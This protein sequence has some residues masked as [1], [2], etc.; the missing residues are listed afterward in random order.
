MFC[1]CLKEN[2]T[3][4]REFSDGDDLDID[5]RLKDDSITY[6]GQ[7]AYLHFYRDRNNK[8][9]IRFT[10]NVVILVEITNCPFCGAILK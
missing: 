10:G 8:Y 1:E 2:I 5:P 4:A 9:Y 3:K 6:D 7:G